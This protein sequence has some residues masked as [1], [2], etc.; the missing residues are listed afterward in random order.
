MENDITLKYKD[1][2]NTDCKDRDIVIHPRTCLSQILLNHDSN[3]SENL[4][5][6]ITSDEL[7]PFKESLLDWLK[8]YYPHSNNSGNN[9]N[10][11]IATSY[12]L[13]GIK[14][15]N[16]LNITEDGILSVN[17][18]EPVQYNFSSSFI[19]EDNNIDLRTASY[20]KLGILKISFENIFSPS[21][22]YNTNTSSIDNQ[23]IFRIGIDSDNRLGT[24]I[25]SNLFRSNLPLA[26]T[27]QGNGIGA[28]CIAR[29]NNDIS[30][31][32]N[33]GRLYSLE[34]DSNNVGCVRIPDS[35]Y[36][37]PKASLD[38]LGG[39]KV[40]KVISNAKIDDSYANDRNSYSVL[41]T[42]EGLAF[43]NIPNVTTNNQSNIIIIKDDL[44]E[45]TNGALVGQST[46]DVYLNIANLLRR[47][48]ISYKES[49]EIYT[50]L[51]DTSKNIKGLIQGIVLPNRASVHGIN[52]NFIVLNS[53]PI[54]IFNYDKSNR[55]ILCNEEAVTDSYYYVIKLEITRLDNNTTAPSYHIEINASEKLLDDTGNEN[56]LI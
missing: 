31:Y 43:V 17:M 4:F 15:G 30:D 50:L 46:G 54:S 34:L 2:C 6:W 40:S 56:I 38:T 5:K 19:V 41:R 12:T 1:L 33:T 42:S 45:S 9:V 29:K 48:P 7:Y 44:D 37:I 24:I 22:F 25:P 52:S 49:L 20:D 13:G 51:G 35:N 27:P 10:L 14:V 11:P 36:E 28:L 55:V 3:D 53:N 16:Y 26:D 39:I 32:T 8:T 18:P 47:F 23:Y 21:N